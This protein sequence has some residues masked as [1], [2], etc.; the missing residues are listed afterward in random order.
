MYLGHDAL[1]PWLLPPH[2][3][4]GFPSPGLPIGKDAH[5]VAFKGVEQHLFS[6]VPIHLLLRCKLGVLRLGQSG[7][8]EKQKE[9]WMSL[10]FVSVPT[11]LLPELMI[12]Q[13][14]YVPSHPHHCPNHP[15]DPIQ[16]LLVL[17]TPRDSAFLSW[18]QSQPKGP[19]T[20]IQDHPPNQPE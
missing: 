13:R 6:N 12:L 4:I 7:G 5:V 11:V 17:I 1:L 10:S 19:T 20:P 14:S 2:H 16:P 9:P 3:G 8:R 15:E 18:P